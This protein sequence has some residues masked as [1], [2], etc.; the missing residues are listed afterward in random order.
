MTVCFILRFAHNAK[1]RPKLP[2]EGRKLILGGRNLRRRR[3]IRLVRFLSVDLALCANGVG[4]T[5][6][7]LMKSLQVVQNENTDDSN[8]VGETSFLE[9]IGYP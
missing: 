8:A 5:L 6:R 3:R 9:S 1:D 4:K 2:A 7:I